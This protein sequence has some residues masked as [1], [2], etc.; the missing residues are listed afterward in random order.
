METPVRHVVMFS[1]GVG[2]WGTA[3]RVAD[4]HGTDNL[5]L[6][7]ADTNTE[8]PDWRPF[9][10]ACHNDIG[11]ELVVLDN[12]GRDIWD[13]FTENRFI[14]NTRADICSRV[15]KREPLRQ[16]LEQHCQPESTVVYLGF[17]W[18]E[19]HRFDRSKPHWAPWQVASPLIDPPYAD[20]RDLLGQLEERGIPI[21]RL[22]GAGFPHNNCGG[23]CVKGGHGQ[24]RRLF[25][26]D[27][28]TFAYHELREQKMRDLLG[29][30]VSVLRDR[31]GGETS[32]Y[33]LAQL[34]DALTQNPSLFDSFNDDAACDCFGG[35]ITGS[36][37]VP[38][39]PATPGDPDFIG[40][41]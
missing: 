28:D 22:Y 14:G 4:R 27:P 39:S 10:E 17:D 41:H 12:G 35:P 31:K 29:K 2:S 38:L 40:G 13:V 37:A 24:W 15:L 30:D 34:R 19:E 32:P 16:W 11:G 18:T 5:T 8:G 23:A 20:K 21:P 36:E 26:Y 6:L 3:R 7:V 9:V 33:T 1:G 25:F